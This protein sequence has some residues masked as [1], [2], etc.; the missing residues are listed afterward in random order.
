LVKDFEEHLMKE[1]NSPNGLKFDALLKVS[2]Y[3]FGENLCSNDT[4]AALEKAIINKFEK[5]VTTDISKIIKLFKSLA[6]YYIKDK[7]LCYKLKNYIETYL[8]GYIGKETN[9]EDAQ[10]TENFEKSDKKDLT[11]VK[12]INLDFSEAYYKVVTNLNFLIWGV[13]KNETFLKLSQKDPEFVYFFN[14]LKEIFIRN[15]EFYNERET[16]FTINGL[17][18]M[19]VEFTPEEIINVNKKI[20]EL[21][22]YVPHDSVMMLKNLFV[23]KLG[24]KESILHL[25]TVSYKNFEQLTYSEL[26][27]F[28]DILDTIPEIFNTLINFDKVSFFEKRLIEILPKVEIKAFCKAI[29]LTYKL[30]SLLSKHFIEKLKE[31]FNSRV[32]EI[33]KE[34]FSD[35]L[36]SLV[37]IKY[38]DGV[39]KMFDILEDLSNFE[40]LEEVFKSP[41][42]NLNLL[43]ACLTVTSQ[44]IGNSVQKKFINKLVENY[45]DYQGDTEGFVDK[46][47]GKFI[48]K[49][50]VY[51][52]DDYPIYEYELNIIKYIQAIYMSAEYLIS[53]YQV[54]KIIYEKLNNKLSLINTLVSTAQTANLVNHD[55][56]SHCDK[57]ILEELQTELLNFFRRKANASIYPN[58]IDSAFS[59]LNIVIVFELPKL[60]KNEYITGIDAKNFGIVLLGSKYFNSE[61]NIL[62]I[63]ENR[64][65]L[66]KDVFNWDIIQITE[67]EWVKAG[68]RQK[69][70]SEKFGFDFIKD[71]NLI[72]QIKQGNEDILQIEN[73]K[74]PK[75]DFT[76]KLLSKKK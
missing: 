65:R 67:G 74:K 39:L 36:F 70:L 75:Y 42:E 9:P 28:I 34:L 6:N 47:F 40:K 26:I 29:K 35:V 49:D 72:I 62:A 8:N 43:W 32:N 76:K 3:I 16:T 45:L 12:T 17:I 64:F 68:N 48:I 18:K 2:E 59:L 30:N 71:E 27:D 53:K 33:P 54:N 61:K 11:I 46:L 63:Y 19:K 52:T 58:F 50:F 51:K 5:K 66:L 24:T 69:F 7:D 21:K 31:V 44:D 10:N 41:I 13:A 60:G 57:Q 37:N 23:N 25:I 4:Q 55:A 20:C 56:A 73:A 1:L 14:R 38:T 22:N 15:L